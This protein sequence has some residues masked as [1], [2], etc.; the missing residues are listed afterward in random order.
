MQIAPRPHAAPLLLH[1]TFWRQGVSGKFTGEIQLREE[2]N[3][4]A[5]ACVRTR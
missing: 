3:S 2:K 4:L 1:R 5:L